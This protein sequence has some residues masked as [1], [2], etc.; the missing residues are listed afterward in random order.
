MGNSMVMTVL[1]FTEVGQKQQKDLPKIL[2][3]ILLKK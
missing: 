3:K 1:Y 2:V